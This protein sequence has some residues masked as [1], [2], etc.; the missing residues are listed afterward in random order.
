MDSPF[1]PVGSG[2]VLPWETHPSLALIHQLKLFNFP[3]PNGI[4]LIQP[5]L[6]LE[7]LE[8]AFFEELQEEIRQRELKS[9]LT[10]SAFGYE[11]S[12]PTFTQPCTL[13]TLGNAFKQAIE[14][15]SR[16]KRLDFLILE[17]MQGFARGLAFSQAGYSDDC[18]EFQLGAPEDS[19]PVTKVFIEKLSLGE[20]RLQGD[21]RGR[22]Q[23]LLRSIRRALGEDNWKIDWIDADENIFLTAIEK[24]TS[25]DFVQDLFLRL[26]RWENTPDT[27]GTLEGT[28]ISACSPKLF[29][30]FHPWAPELS[31]ERPF[32][33]WRQNQLQFNISLVS[34]FLRG[35]G[36]STRSLKLLIPDFSLP[37]IPLNTIRFW[38]SL[39]RLFRFLRDLT[40]GPGIA[41]RLVKKLKLF[42]TNPEK[43]FSE[44][45]QEWQS[46]FIASS[47]A[48]YRLST[49]LLI[50]RYGS[51]L[52]PLGK[53]EARVQLAESL[54]R[55][56][57]LEALTKIYSAIQI[58]ALGWY[59]RGL[60]SSDD[61]IWSMSQDQ[62]LA[63]EGQ[64][65]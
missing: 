62:I 65:E 63:L 52:L 14:N 49:F 21:F 32:V 36:L 42:Q 46:I 1:I 26:P 34:D 18:I 40:L 55:S 22:V 35:F 44:L 41:Y 11:E 37:V 24:N 45:F 13:E 60:L 51:G 29:Q 43:P 50:I 58:K 7:S 53:L 5:T 57:T 9:D 47:H 61:A 6:N 59:S 3:I 15:L 8:P 54:L 23:D 4:I 17:R 30:Y 28:V 20:I 64:L 56:A 33:I 31:D 25:S 39:P 48:Q 12:V 2:Q 16:S 10:L 38:R 19:M 27:P